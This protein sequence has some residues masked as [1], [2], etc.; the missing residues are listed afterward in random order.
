MCTLMVFAISISRDGLHNGLR[1]F[2]GFEF[3]IV[4]KNNRLI[5]IGQKKKK[6][7]P[8]PIDFQLNKLYV[9][10]IRKHRRIEYNDM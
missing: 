1:A 10:S 4:K 9:F 7:K 2:D 5:R 3:L 8:S 6:K